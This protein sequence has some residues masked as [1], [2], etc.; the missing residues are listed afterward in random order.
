MFGL[1]QKMYNVRLYPNQNA[2]KCARMFI[3]EKV[4]QYT[5]D[6]PDNIEA[7]KF[8]NIKALGKMIK[9]IKNMEIMSQVGTN[10]ERKRRM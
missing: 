7:E 5:K 10:R 6:H 2:E 4:R 3:E 1:L 9:K 8:D